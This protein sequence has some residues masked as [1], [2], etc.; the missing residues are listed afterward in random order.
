MF[1]GKTIRR[2]FPSLAELLATVHHRTYMEDGLITR[3][4]ADFLHDKKFAAAYAKGKATGSWNGSNPRWRVYT[5]CW[6][7]A[8]AAQLPGDFVECGVNRGG[9]ALTIL[10]YLN[11]NSLNK[12]F[13]LLDTFQGFPK[14]AQPSEA[15]VGL[16]E[17][18]YEDA[19]KTFAP[20]SGVVIVR[21]EVP[22]TLSQITSEQIAYLSIDMNCA[23]P[24]IAVLRELW[25][26]LVAGAVVLLDDYGYGP[27]HSGQQLAFDTLSREMKFTILTTPTGQGMVIKAHI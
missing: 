25:P 2:L 9:M 17:D 18:C 21:G 10:E 3:H 13:F 19:V 4:T 23:E 6:A 26:R 7:A 5:A 27:A 16:Y 12:K 1:L 15:N 14:G 11:F 8:Y 24:E 22:G 20:Y